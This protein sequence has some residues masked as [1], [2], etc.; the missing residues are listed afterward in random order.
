MKR[1]DYISKSSYI[2][3]ENN[4]TLVRHFKWGEELVCHRRMKEDNSKGYNGTSDEDSDNDDY[5]E[6]EDEYDD[7]LDKEYHLNYEYIRKAKEDN[8]PSKY[9]NKRKMKK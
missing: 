8:W 3:S 6:E 7:E 1:G 4:H 9:F 5:D 2:I